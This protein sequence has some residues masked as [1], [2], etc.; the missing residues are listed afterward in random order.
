VLLWLYSSLLD[1]LLWLRGARRR[2]L[3]LGPVE[4]SYFHLERR[5]AAELAPWV[6]LHGLGGQAA[7]TWW[8]EFAVLGRDCELVAPDLGFAGATA[9]PGGALTVRAAADLVIRTIE[10][11]FGGRPAT[12]A[13][14]SL[15]GWIAVRAALSRPDLVA[16]LVLIDAAGYRD[17]DWDRV[18][19]L[20]TINDLAGVDRIYRALFHRVPWHMRV[21]KRAFLAAYTSAGVRTLLRETQESDTYNRADLASLAIPT[22]LIW[23]EFDGLFS[24]ETAREM[25]AALPKAR[26]EVLPA[27]GHAVHIECPLALARALRR[28]QDGEFPPVD[29]RNQAVAPAGRKV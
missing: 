16:R 2:H 27:C 3:V 24:L 19:S 9:A 25:T 20:V 22:T 7:A 12:L 18:Q 6:L 17:Q 10:R 11:D 14:L 5:P 28:V 21:S 29:T 1:L 8:P 15:G 13:G 26:L 23:G 4:F